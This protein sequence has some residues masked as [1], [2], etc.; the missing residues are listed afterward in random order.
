MK[1]QNKR[2]I[3]TNLTATATILNKCDTSNIMENPINY[4]DNDE[5]DYVQVDDDTMNDV[6]QS[7]IMEL[8]EAM[9]AQAKAGRPV[10]E[11]KP[12]KG[13]LGVYANSVL[14]GNQPGTGMSGQA[15]GSPIKA[16]LKVGAGS[17]QQSQLQGVSPLQVGKNGQLKKNTSAN[18]MKCDD[19]K[20]SGDGEKA[21]AGSGNSFLQSKS[22]SSNFNI[23][24]VQNCE[25]I[26]NPD[27]MNN[28]EN[29]EGEFSED[30]DPEQLD[31]M[32]RRKEEIEE[33]FTE[34]SMQMKHDLIEKITKEIEDEFD[35]EHEDEME[36]KLSTETKKLNKQMD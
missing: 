2:K 36:A 25:D 15:L 35:S 10:Y 8:T 26:D 23:L 9:G 31:E 17:D 20:M 28:I 1:K 3:N 34:K 21:N 18:N 33:S 22:G 16:T 12:A 30:D 14:T 6:S 29:Q 32:E 19:G 4:E 24:R 5:F 13:E 7:D 11:R 27:E